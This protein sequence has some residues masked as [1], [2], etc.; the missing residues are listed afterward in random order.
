MSELHDNLNSNLRSNIFFLCEKESVKISQSFDLDKFFELNNEFCDNCKEVLG[1][2]PELISKSPKE[3]LEVSGLSP[4]CNH[5][6][7][8]NCN[9][10]LNPIEEFYS[11]DYSKHPILPIKQSY[12]LCDCTDS[13][14]LPTYCFLLM[15]ESDKIPDDIAEKEKESLERG[16]FHWLGTT[17]ITDTECYG[18]INQAKLSMA[19]DFEEQRGVRKFL[20][21][22]LPNLTFLDKQLTKQFTPFF[23]TSRTKE[24]LIRKSVNTYS[25]LYS[26]LMELVE[27]Y[28]I[29]LNL[30]PS[31]VASSMR[32]K[33]R[34]NPFA[35]LT[36]PS[37][38]LMN[39][40]GI[41]F[42]YH[43]I[44]S[45][46]D[47]SVS[48]VS[49]MI[50]PVN[51][52]HQITFTRFE[53]EE[54]VKEC[55]I[56]EE[57]TLKIVELRKFAK[58]KGISAR[59][60]TLTSHLDFEKTGKYRSAN[61]FLAEKKYPKVPLSDF[62]ECVERLMKI[63][64]VIA[65]YYGV[66]MSFDFGFVEELIALASASMRDTTL[67]FNRIEHSYTLEFTKHDR[68]CFSITQSD[69]E[70]TQKDLQNSESFM[71]EFRKGN[72]QI[73]VDKDSEQVIDLRCLPEKE[74]LLEYLN[75][76]DLRF[77]RT[78]EG[79]YFPH[80]REP[81]HILVTAFNRFNENRTDSTRL[82][83]SKNERL[84]ID[85]LK[86]VVDI[87]NRDILYQIGPKLRSWIDAFERF[88]SVGPIEIYFECFGIDTYNPARLGI[89]EI[90]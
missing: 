26:L 72:I 70:E 21:K 75:D 88:E 39:Y 49:S 32:I 41:S 64:N 58:E 29:C 65:D 81:D 62:R 1:N 56:R 59:R 86:T 68:Y 84:R 13:I 33:N 48:K 46:W 37:L 5:K 2:S 8:K 12:Y 45:T 38:T 60:H 90:Q 54:Y 7:C 55:E 85:K 87:Q 36:N 35:R 66:N 67:L 61:D 47:A 30:N 71:S 69:I 9:K 18:L 31:I 40:S 77:F 20:I 4:Y 11:N 82:P 76:L 22:D 23:E 16:T 28:L 25:V 24:D 44:E 27:E 52:P 6:T 89:M 74:Y 14:W 83:F 80:I 79:K 3:L 53:K 51:K 10:V 19:G 63:A 78:S 15:D 73:V 17:T 42:W 43:L 50:E 57:I 34:S